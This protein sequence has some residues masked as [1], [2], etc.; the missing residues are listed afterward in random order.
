MKFATNLDRSIFKTVRGHT[1]ANPQTLMGIIAGVDASERLVLTHEE[2]A[3]GLERLLSAGYIAETQPHRF[4]DASNGNSPSAFS[5]ITESDY[6]V[7]VEEYR[8]WFQQHLDDLDDELGEDGFVWKKLVL[9][10]TTPNNRWPTDDDEDGAEQLAASLDPIVAQS[11]LGEINGFE[12]GAG[13]IDL[14]IFGKATDS[15]VDQI[16][17]LLAPAFRAFKCPA[18]S[19]IIR[20]YRERDEKIESDVVP[21]H[22]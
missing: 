13:H 20:F 1:P 12:Q 3:S 2:L 11:G 15:D 16:Y 7:A 21:D 18:G 6:A 17:E 22:Q 9:R 8:N 4:C 19:R 5:G 10:W 14:L